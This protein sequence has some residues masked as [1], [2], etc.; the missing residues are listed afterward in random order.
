[1]DK[2]KIKLTKKRTF[3]KS[4]WYDWHD[5][6]INYTPETI[7][8][9]GG[10]KNRI[11]ILCKTKDYSQP[12]LVKTVYEDGKK[13]IKLKIQKQ[14]ENNIIKNIRNLFKLKKENKAIR[15]RTARIERR[16]LLQTGKC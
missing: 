4:A 11:M 10:V 13:P 3:M 2:L 8:A 6:L 1:M 7:K 14:S 9:V 5:W 16:R 12:K 15:D